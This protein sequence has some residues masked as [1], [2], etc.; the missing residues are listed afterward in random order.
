MTMTAP[1]FTA[2]HHRLARQIIAHARREGMAVG[3]HL[4]AAPLAE[5]FGVSRTP[6]Q[7]AL[8]LLA[9]QGVVQKRAKRGFF[10]AGQDHVL[11]EIGDTDLQSI[12]DQVYWRMANDR[13]DDTLPNPVTETDLMR[14]YDQPRT[15]IF[16]VLQRMMREGLVAP[17]EGKGWLMTA[18]IRTPEESQSSYRF[19][20]RIE[21]AAFEEPDYAPDPGAL[22]N[23]RR[24]QEHMIDAADRPNQAIG[25]FE[26]NARFH[27]TIVAWSGNRFLL[28][29]IEQHNRLRRLAQYRGFVR[30]KRIV[31]S[32]SE[33]LSILDAIAT[34]DLDLARSRLQEHLSNAPGAT[35]ILPMTRSSK[36]QHES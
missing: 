19:R 7:G 21:P 5:R 28:G 12:E 1:E 20:M 36:D 14:R 15:M 34:G 27:E 23:L 18:I 26:R 30:P 16:R 9:E 4:S 10:L 17:R 8:H 6:V 11:S 31:Q 24:E 32:A 25:N 2:L 22:T 35:S 3:A 29:A 13:I 33:H